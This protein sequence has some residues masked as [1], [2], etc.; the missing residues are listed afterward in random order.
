METYIKDLNLSPEVKTAL[1]WY[2][3]ITKV[4]DLEGLNY[5]TFAN[6]C[7]KNCNVLAIADELNALGYLYSPENEISVNDIPMSKRL[8]NVLIYNNILYLSQLSIHPREEILKFRNLGESTMPELD[9]ICENTV[10]RCAH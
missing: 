2:L 1:S 7:P 4:S 9:S 6:R 3:H 8:Q 10:S 5:L